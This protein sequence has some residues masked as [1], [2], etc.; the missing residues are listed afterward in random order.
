MTIFDEERIPIMPNCEFPKENAT[1]A[2]I[3]ELLKS[4]KV[5]AVVGLS[6][7]PERPSYGVSTYMKDQGYTI[8]PVNPGQKEILDEK[9]YP[10]LLDIPG[11]VDMVNIF[12]ESAAVPEIVDQAIQIKAKSIWMQ[13]GVVHNEAAEKARA[14]GLKVVMN[15]CLYK[16]HIRL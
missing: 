5:I 13:E 15:K 11:P 8:I 2:E 14:A 12:R 7:K 4:T 9:A 3:A 16:E 6:P 10:S 1:S